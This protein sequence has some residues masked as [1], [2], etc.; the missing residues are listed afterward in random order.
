LEIMAVE[1]LPA[2]ELI[3]ATELGRMPL[4]ESSRAVIVVPSLSL[5]GPSV[6]ALLEYL[7]A[8]GSLLLLRPCAG[9]GSGLG[10]Q[11]AREVDS[12]LLRDAYLELDHSHPLTAP[13]PKD[14]P[15]LQYHGQADAYMPDSQSTAARVYWGGSSMPYPIVLSG[16]LGRGRYV[17]FAYDLARSTML[18]HQGLRAQSSLGECPDRSGDS[19]YTPN[20]LFVGYLD[21][22]LRLVPQADLQQRMFSG[23]LDWLARE[24]LPLPRLWY[25]PRSRPAVAVIDGDSDAMTV[26]EMEL[27]ARTLEKGG[28]RYTL[29]L[30]TDHYSAVTGELMDSY[31]ERGHD[32]GPHIWLALKPSPA[33]FHAHVQREVAAFSG[34]YGFRPASTRHHCVVWPG[35]MEPAQALARAGIGMEM[36]FRAAQHFREGY[37]TG[38]GLPLRY[39]DEEGELIDV[40]QQS[41]LLSDDFLFQNKSFRTPLKTADVI[42]L[43]KTMVDACVQ[44]YHTVF[45]PYFH[46]VYGRTHP[47]LVPGT[48]TVPWLEATV[49]HCRERG[50][51]MLAAS[52]WSGFSLARREALPRDLDWDAADFRLRFRL[53]Q[54]A[55]PARDLAGLTLLLPLAW[56]GCALASVTQGDG[57]FTWRREGWLGRE[58][59]VFEVEADSDRPIEARYVTRG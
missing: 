52:E 16:R 31:R 37:L 30:M 54:T 25:Y 43:T 59:A 24:A 34:R 47:P 22:D 23:A 50:L 3:A 32:F 11:P 18:F 8:G 19:T 13:V 48:Y 10:L 35:W 51:P 2:P 17:V 41:T 14:I 27:Y 42:A 55:L 6:A 57:P 53:G 29:Y 39:V 58:N 21:A 33:K 46:P 12:N 45:H 4:A 28:G 7:R 15:Y 44:R 56:R 38:S 40:Q 49:A 20:D 36:N 5:A 1:G 26:E 9:L